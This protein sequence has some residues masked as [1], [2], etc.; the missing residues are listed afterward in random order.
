MFAAGAADPSLETFRREIQPVLAKY[1]YDCHGNGIDKGG[2]TLDSFESAASLR[3]HEL[4]SRALRN[5][6]SGIMPPADEAK[7]T[8][9]EAEKVMAWIKRDAFGLDP[10]KPDPGRVT[11]RRL[12][13]VEY[14]NTVRDLTGVDYP[15]QKEF[16]ADDTGHGF[17]NIADVLTI[18]PMLLEKYL[19]AAQAII[20]E[21]VVTKP[22][23][24]AEKRVLGR[25]FATVKVDTTQP[26]PPK[27]AAPIEAAPAAPVAVVADPPP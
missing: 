25:E 10:G 6:R 13:R 21:A 26:E 2:V 14:R 17:D 7:P 12:N 9:A 5:I 15:T 23:M 8:A 22:R 18:S 24:V 16:P 4:W 20:G 11:V 1:C 27:P 19:D 3:D